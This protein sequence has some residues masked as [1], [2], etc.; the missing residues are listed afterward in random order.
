MRRI[1]AENFMY[2]TYIYVYKRRRVTT[3]SRA[4]ITVIIINKS[5][6]AY[7]YI[8]Y[9]TLLLLYHNII[10]HARIYTFM[11]F[12]CTRL[13]SCALTRASINQRQLFSP[14]RARTCNTYIRVLLP[15]EDSAKG[16]TNGMAC[17]ATRPPPSAGNVLN[18]GCAE[19]TYI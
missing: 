12:H 3:E 6:N 18:N 11:Y 9:Y 17:T 19:M 14:T 7:A 16:R 5:T 8:A 15:G 10:I 1:L 13:F 4:R 2:N